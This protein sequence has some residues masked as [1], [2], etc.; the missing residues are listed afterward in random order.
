[1][2]NLYELLGINKK[3]TKQEIK[4]AYKKASSK[5]HPDK[6]GDKD[7]FFQVKLAYDVLSN[8]VRKEKYDNTGDTT[9][10]NK[11]VDSVESQLTSLF[12]SIIDQENF[13]GNIIDTAKKTVGDVITNLRNGLEVTKN[14]LAKLEKNADR[15]KYKGDENIFTILMIGKINLLKNQI[16]ELE[17]KNKLLEGVLIAL[18]A[19][20][21]T[22]SEEEPPIMFHNCQFTTTTSGFGGL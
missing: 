5:T 13:N 16:I 21:D 11:N 22:L 19:Y 15:I 8:P 14:K 7:E 20:E 9:D 4:K 18:L 10:N 12:N 3:S 17:S 1:M 2:I 6:G